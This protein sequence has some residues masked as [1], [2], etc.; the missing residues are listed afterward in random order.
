M[1]ALLTAGIA[2]G[3]SLLG[4]LFN[5]SSQSKTNDANQQLAREQ[6][7]FNL[8]MQQNEFAQN[9]AQS[10]LEYQR[11]LELWNMQNE[12]NSPQAQMQRYIDAGLNPNLIYGTGSASSGNASAPQQF[13]A[14]RYDAP[15]AERATKVAPQVDIHQAINV[16]QQ[17]ALRR[18]QL[19]NVEA[20][21]EQVKQATKN[22]KVD[23]L[24]KVYEAG[25]KSLSLQLRRE[26]YDNDILESNVRLRKLSNEADVSAHQKMILGYQWRELQ[27]LQRQKLAQEIEFLRLT[28]DTE[29]FKN[30]LLK[31]GVTDKDGF[32]TRLASR[33]LLSNEDQIRELLNTINPFK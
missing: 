19:D 10:E 13:T 24:I 30:R 16:A 6:N 25:G 21:T 7:A 22:S 18:A 5:S 15:R 4:G 11:N 26:L 8:Q 1:S 12:Y 29:S 27:P 9:S 28:Y 20:Q 32:I 23:E 2:A 33:A 17:F 14:A 31:L 3:T